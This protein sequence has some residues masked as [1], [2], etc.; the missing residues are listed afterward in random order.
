MKQKLSFSY[1][2]LAFF[3]LLFA[4][5]HNEVGASKEIKNCVIGPDNILTKPRDTTNDGRF[6]RVNWTAVPNA[7]GY[8]LSAF[9]ESR[10][11]SIANP[12][13]V[14]Q[15]TGSLTLPYTCD[16]VL[17]RI[18]PILPS[19]GG[20]LC[21]PDGQN[22]RLSRPRGGITAIIIERTTGGTCNTNTSLKFFNDS[23]FVIGRTPVASTF[24]EGVS[25]TIALDSTFRSKILNN[26]DGAGY[27]KIIVKN[28]SGVQTAVRDG[29]VT[30]FQTQGSLTELSTAI[31]T[32][33]GLAGIPNP[34]TN[35]NAFI[36]QIR[37]EK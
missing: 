37:F 1:A 33:A 19:T 14:T 5:C 25:S 20:T 11:T 4:A 29:F 8:L 21:I 30:R 31:L 27:L 3:L 16:S 22:V 17:F 36:E 28:C 7:T 24:S 35:T 13:T 10:G 26:A 15:A 34:T 9:N 2:I 23:S 32:A 12:I 6:Y 18:K